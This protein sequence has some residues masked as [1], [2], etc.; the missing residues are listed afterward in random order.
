MNFSE[1]LNNNVVY[2]DGGMGT[3]L[4]ERGLLPGE[5]P[6]RWNITH[7]DVIRE[8]HKSYFDV[9]SNVVLTNTFGA[10]RLKFDAEELEEIIKAAIFA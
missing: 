10:N 6:E 5:Y 7:P 1:F 3:L 2:L 4:Q 9:G 8:I